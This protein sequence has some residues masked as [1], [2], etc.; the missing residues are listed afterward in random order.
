MQRKK[1]GVLMG[2][3]WRLVNVIPIEDE[4]DEVWHIVPNKNDDLL[5][6]SHFPKGVR[7]MAMKNGK[8]PNCVDRIKIVKG[9]FDYE[10][11]SYE[12][13]GTGK[14]IEGRLHR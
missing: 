7:R 4:I 3:R 12:V 6:I 9:S 2:K 13:Y 14:W 8:V 10:T 11:K 1:R 5:R